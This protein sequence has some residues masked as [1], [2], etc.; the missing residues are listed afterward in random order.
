MVA[1]GDFSL[2][3]LS[4]PVSVIYDTDMIPHITAR[5]TED[6]MYMQGYITAKH[7]LWHMELQILS[8]AGRLSE[9]VGP[10]ALESDRLN[11]RKGLMFGAEN[12]LFEL[13]KHPGAMKIL[14][15][16]TAGINAWIAQLDPEDYPIEYKILDYAPE[17]WTPIN[18]I[19]LLKYMSNNLSNY[20]TDLEQTNLLKMIGRSDLDLLFPLKPMDV[21]PIIPE[22]TAF[23][24]E[25]EPVDTP[26]TRFPLTETNNTQ[27]KPDPANGSN[28]F[29]VGGSK[30]MSGNPILAN[31]PDLGLN[32][33]SLWFV[34]QLQSPDM[35]VMGAS[36]PGAPGIIIG[37]N[38]SIA[39]GVTNAR[40]DVRDW[41]EVS[42]R[43]DNREEYR[44]GDQWLKVQ[45]RIEVIKV[46]GE[47]DVIDTVLYTHHGPVTYEGDFDQR[48]GLKGF[49]TRWPGHDPSIEM[50]AFHQL[51]KAK[52]VEGILDAL[53][54]FTGP[55]Q[56]F[57]FASA[58]GDIGLQVTGKFPKK[59]QDQGR[60]L[61]DGSNPEHDWQ[62]YIPYA[63]NAKA[64]NPE[65]GFLSSAN[66]YP[67]PDNY[68]YYTYDPI[69]EHYRNRRINQVLDSL[70]RFTQLDAKNLQNDN[71]NLMASDLLPF[72]LDSL[73][74]SGIA[75][76]G[77]E[78]LT[79]L[80]S[81]DYVHG[82]DSEGA[83]YFDLWQKRLYALLWDE[84]TD[85]DVAVKR[86]TAWR[87][88]E[89]LKLD[90]AKHYFDIMATSKVET[91]N[92]LI[93]LSFDEMVD[94]AAEW[95]EANDRTLVW[96]NYNNHKVTHLLKAA[97]FSH[98]YVEIGGT[99]STVNAANHGHG[100]S[101]RMVVEL[102]PQVKA[103]G[104]Y[105]GGQSGNPGSRWYDN[106]LNRWASA[107][108]IPLEFAP[109]G[110]QLSN[111][112]MATQSFGPQ[113]N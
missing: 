104:I 101:W 78:I 71:L 90:T 67:V 31:E 100:P 82:P 46:R 57:V 69:Y 81:W 14:E 103:W 43:N 27:P 1:S 26:S 30:T 5:S 74:R 48:A 91:A 54:N 76:E 94:Q 93:R 6:A 22:G 3:G 85:L 92:D 111:D 21:D 10:I 105:P 68:P 87:S 53:S 97:A 89:L 58:Q 60:F 24:F 95:K 32:L 109:K 28:N 19:L 110:Q 49:A 9:V 16:Y 34:L 61:M 56:N 59:W 65:Q 72:L 39:W 99:Y 40:R 84:F 33:P 80:E 35:N 12:G 25:P 37:F 11:R 50:L 2:P 15:S 18:S 44:Y 113:E 88:I 52:N 8:A 75:G 70:N 79:V 62:G 86:P 4:A 29:V 98:E 36:L 23:D 73:D 96:K 17:E 102:G 42:F 7:R 38:D 66:Q 45:R 47:E 51:N 55:A 41:Y 63:H 106:M 13:E 20:E 108:Y 77:L 83:V 64:I 107:E 112:V